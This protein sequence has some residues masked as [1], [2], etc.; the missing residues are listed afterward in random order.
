MGK[1]SYSLYLWHLP[2]LYF[3]EIYLAGIK[4]YVI[5]LITSLMLSILSYHFFENPIRKSRNF[6]QVTIQFLKKFHIIFVLF[7][8]IFG[9]F[10]NNFEK[11]KIFES[12]KKFNYP[13]KKLEN[14]LKRLDYKYLDYLKADCKFREDLS[15]CKK[16]NISQNSVYITGDSHADHFLVS[17]DNLDS[18]KE[19][20]FNNFAQCKIILNSFYNTKQTNFINNCEKKYGKN[21]EK[22]ILKNLEKYQN[23]TIII[24]LRLSTY[25]SSD[26]KLIPK[27]SLSKSEVIV[28]NYQRFISLFEKTNVV[29]ITTVPESKIHSEKCIFNEFLR[30]R[31]DLKIFN[32]CHFKKTNDN[33][34]YNS[35]KNILNKISSKN[36][37]VFVYDP[38]PIFCPSLVC[39]NYNKKNDF[40]LLIDKDHLSIE[41]G[42]FISDDISSFLENI[43]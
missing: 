32:K 18:L 16:N 20:S 10:I 24:S 33:T 34:R 25:L 9:F 31:I 6:N 40:F 14:Y 27:Q 39:H 19:Y 29:L 1:L 21:F 42:K 30:N 43:Y 22:I 17:L 11:N 41:A 15:I 13:E 28:N 3:C 12:F 7:L 38:Y 5:F 23:K 26:W 8:I 36:K 37:N 35:I 4:L 2:V